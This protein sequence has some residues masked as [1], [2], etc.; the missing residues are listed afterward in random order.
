MR[1]LCAEDNR[2]PEFYSDVG[3]SL[4]SRAFVSVVA[5]TCP[6]LERFEVLGPASIRLQLPYDGKISPISRPTFEALFGVAVV[7]RHLHVLD[8]F[9][10][11]RDSSSG[12]FLYGLVLS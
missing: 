9:D 4:A 12:N 5:R 10:E 3:P 11:L 7:L 8:S 1:H 2:H 6:A